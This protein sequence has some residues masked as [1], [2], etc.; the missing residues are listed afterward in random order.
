MEKITLIYVNVIFRIL[1][2]VYKIHFKKFLHSLSRKTVNLK[3]S[4]TIK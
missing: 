2:N 1:E 4:S 3:C